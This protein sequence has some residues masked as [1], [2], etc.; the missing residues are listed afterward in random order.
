MRKRPS[1]CV[2]DLSHLT[3]GDRAALAVLLIRVRAAIPPGKKMTARTSSA[4]KIPSR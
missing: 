4:A 3:R 2:I 1:G